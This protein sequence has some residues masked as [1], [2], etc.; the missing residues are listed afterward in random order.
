MVKQQYLAPEIF[1]FDPFASILLNVCDPT[2]AKW[3]KV[4]MRCYTVVWCDI[5]NFA[6]L[7]R[8]KSPLCLNSSSLCL[9]WQFLVTRGTRILAHGQALKLSLSY[10]LTRLIRRRHPGAQQFICITCSQHTPSTITSKS[11]QRCSRL[12][13]SALFTHKFLS[14]HTA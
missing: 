10:I 8:M 2:A 12:S 7:A 1:E 14:K 4:R 3:C 9:R 13:K 5:F 6:T 11:P